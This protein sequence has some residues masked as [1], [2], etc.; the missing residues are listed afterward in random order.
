MP[1][2]RRLLGLLPLLLLLGQAECAPVESTLRASVNTL[3]PSLVQRW[4]TAYR[5]QRQDFEAYA[6]DVAIGHQAG[7]DAAK[8]GRYDFTVTTAAVS[9]AMQPQMPNVKA[10]PLINAAMV[11]FYN[12]PESAGRAQLILTMRASC[13]I[14][15]G[16]IT[17]WNDPRITVS[18]PS[19]ALPSQP[20]TVVALGFEADVMS[21]VSRMCTKVDPGWSAAGLGIST[22]HPAV[23]GLVVVSRLQGF[24]G[25]ASTVV[26]RPYSF[27]WSTLSSAAHVRSIRHAALINQAGNVAQPDQAH[28]NQNFIESA[29]RGLV[30]QGNTFDLTDPLNAFAW[31]VLMGGWLLVDSGAVVSTCATKRSVLQF[32]LWLYESPVAA[33]LARSEHMHLLPTLYL[34]Q[35]LMLEHMRA[36]M[37]C[38]GAPLLALSTASASYHG[39]AMIRDSL[40]MFTDYYGSVDETYSWTYTRA[41]DAMALTRLS[42]GEIDFAVVTT[43]ALKDHDID[44]F[45]APYTETDARGF[46]VTRPG[47]MIFPAYLMGTAFSFLLPDAV[48]NLYAQWSTQDTLGLPPLFPLQIDIDGVEMMFTGAI[49]SWTAPHMLRFN[50]QLQA[51]FDRTGA[52]PALR[53]VACCSDKSDPMSAGTLYIK[54]GL[55]SNYSKAAYAHLDGLVPV[56]D[57]WQADIDAGAP[58]DLIDSESRMEARLSMNPGSVT[59]RPITTDSFDPTADFLLVQR[60]TLGETEAIEP[61]PAALRRCI[62]AKADDE[63]MLQTGVKNVKNRFWYDAGLPGCYPVA[64]QVSI[65]VNSHHTDKFASGAGSANAVQAGGCA[66]AKSVLQMLAW[67]QTSDVMSTASSAVGLVRMGDFDSLRQH[68]VGEVLNSAT[69]DGKTILITLPV[70]WEAGQA[71]FGLAVA[72]AALIGALC[73]LAIGVLLHFRTHPAIRGSSPL[74]LIQV[75]LG[76]LLLSA[77]LPLWASSATQSGCLAFQWLS[78]L[79]FTLAFAPLFA[80]TWRIYQIFSARR[81]KVRKISD[82]RLAGLVAAMLATDL[83]LLAVWSGISP[84]KPITYER[85]F[86]GSADGAIELLTHCSVDSRGMGFLGAAA[87]YKGILLVCGALLSFSTRKVAAQFNESASTAW[88]IYNVVFSGLIVTCIIVFIDSVGAT[89]QFLVLVLLLWITAVTWAFLMLPRFSA[90]W[91]ARAADQ[92]HAFDPHSSGTS[93]RSSGHSS[94]LYSFANIVHMGAA[95]LGSYAKSLEA[96]LE[97]VRQR[98][99]ELGV[100]NYRLAA[101]GGSGATDVASVTHKLPE[102]AVLSQQHTA[103]PQTPTGGHARSP[104]PSLLHAGSALLHAQAQAQG[105]GLSRRNVS[106][107]EAVA[108]TMQAQGGGAGAAPLHV[109]SPPP[110]SNGAV[111]RGG[112]IEQAEPQQQQQQSLQ[113]PQAQAQQA[114][115]EQHQR[116]PSSPSDTSPGATG[117]A[118]SLPYTWS[119]A[120]SGAAPGESD[121]PAS[122]SASTSPSSASGAGV[123]GGGASPA[124]TP[125]PGAATP[126]VRVS[127]PT[128]LRVS[129]ATRPSSRAAAFT[130]K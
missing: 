15:R 86:A 26:D 41:D 68:I 52:S 49:V 105:Q 18:N 5:L 55:R 40:A 17:H 103:G 67:L 98:L 7:M 27:A 44:S 10:Y 24:L 85:A 3:Y 31:P 16:N 113:Q 128:P 45:L 94:G 71:A 74:F 2:L 8:S 83:A 50:P 21:M 37:R 28:V 47:G 126:S 80:K 70:V 33:A 114:Q 38:D 90:L 11:P 62:E 118:H 88:A 124:A 65:A 112:A 4:V 73:L 117:V 61:T 69:C 64:G 116:S 120:A 122:A 102:V 92:L 59:Y 23:A 115:P 75:A 121:A 54:V 9:E 95:Q 77:S 25:L 51:W 13:E 57:P 109:A 119:D 104:S 81:I 29:A 99:R 107:S 60:N 108:A 30:A 66:R 42:A 19:L 110:G 129:I 78:N 1:P 43:S 84:L 6:Q 97:R 130:L 32:L 48:M 46:S 125:T 34:E 36:D 93:L 76:L 12:L 91:G 89:L 123:G 111:S 79:G 35:S 58:I 63:A 96:Q 127:P 56:I 82:A 39:N 72:A 87:A 101:S 106:L 22:T 20:I 100:K 53:A 14:M